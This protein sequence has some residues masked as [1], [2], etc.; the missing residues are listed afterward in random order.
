MKA[1]AFKNGPVGSENRAG[2]LIGFT[3]TFV[4]AF[5]CFLS[6]VLIFQS[7]HFPAC[8]ACWDRLPGP[9]TDVSG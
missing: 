4:Y 8:P 3:S 6:L 9:I 1:A 7:I 2:G 5:V